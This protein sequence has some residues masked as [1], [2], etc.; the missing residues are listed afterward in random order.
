LRG[1]VGRGC[2]VGTPPARSNTLSLIYP[3]CVASIPRSP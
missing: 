3:I 1:F 2:L